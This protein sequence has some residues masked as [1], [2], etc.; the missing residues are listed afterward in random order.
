MNELGDILRGGYEEAILMNKKEIILVTGQ[1]GIKVRE[2]LEKLNQ[3]SENKRQIVSIEDRI[4]DLSNMSFH[5]F[6]GSP[7]YRQYEYWKK[8]FEQI[9]EK[10]FKQQGSAESIF[11]TF[12]AVYYHQK[13][14]ELFPPVSFESL[15]KLKDRVKM[16]IVFIDDIYDVYRRLMDKGQMFEDV[17]DDKKTQPL[18]AIF[19]SIFNIISLL[20]WREM[21]ISLSRAIANIVNTKIFVVSTKHPSFMIN[22]L[23]ETPL[24]NLKIYYLSHPITAIREE[25]A[26]SLHS[27]IGRLESLIER[28]LGYPNT[29]LFFPTSIDELIIKREKINKDKYYYYPEL[30]PRWSHPYKNQLL[31]PL[32]PPKFKNLNPLNP[33]NYSLSIDKTNPVSSAVSH[34]IS[35]LWNFIYLKQIISRDYSLVEQSENGIIACR[36]YFEGLRAGGVIGELSYNFLLMKKQSQ[37]KSFIFS[38]REDKNKLAIHRLFTELY[39]YLV[40]PPKNLMDKKDNWIRGNYDIIE[41]QEEEIRKELE[42]N[43][44]PNDY[45]FNIAQSQD[46]WIGDS[47]AKKTYRREE[48]FKKIFKDIQTDEISIRVDVDKDIEEG[49]IYNIYMEGEFWDKTLSFI[50]NDFKSK[51]ANN[52]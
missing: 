29:V 51:E 31:S 18:D 1:S 26:T 13:K 43:I 38:C 17:L 25:A 6:I 5:E 49:V 16:L 35:L 40:E 3:Q 47:L 30:I 22:R 48:V 9:Y 7:Q 12:H 44:L 41:K 45:D 24:D 11:L 50:T 8:A 21:E 15:A 27:F 33:L 37:R 23:I 32:L 14:R 34:L 36:P 42:K 39:N 10:Y 28:I 19:S 46:E 20:N 4:G 2:C 52:A